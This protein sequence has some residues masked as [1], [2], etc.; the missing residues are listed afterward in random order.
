[1][2]KTVCVDRGGNMRDMSWA[3]SLARV[4]AG[5]VVKAVGFDR[6]SSMRF[7]AAHVTPAVKFNGIGSGWWSIRGPGSV[8]NTGS[9][10]HGIIRETEM[11]R[12]WGGML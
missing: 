11:D 2:V 10:D 3:L 9:F 1:M 6:G 7:N 12:G 8:A 4:W 5:V